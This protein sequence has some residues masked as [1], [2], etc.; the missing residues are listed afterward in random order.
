M[1]YTLENLSAS[2]HI[3]Q[4]EGIIT[5]DRKTATYKLALFRA[6]SEIAVNESRVAVWFQDDEVG[7]PLK[8]I[9]EKWVQYYW[10]LFASDH[11]IPQIRGE[12][13]ESSKPIKFGWNLPNLVEH[14][15]DSGGLT[16][17]VL[18][19]RN[20]SLFPAAEK[21]LQK[22]TRSISQ[23]IIE[24][25]VRH[26]GRALQTGQ[27]FRYDPSKKM[28]LMDSGIWRELSLMAH[29]ILGALKL[30]WAEI[31]SDMSN[32]EVPAGEVLNLLLT[33]PIPE[34]EVGDARKVYSSIVDKECVWSGDPLKRQF[35]VDHVIPFSLWGNNDLWNLLPALS[36]VNRD[37]KDRLPSRSL[38]FRRRD[39]IIY[40][41]RE[42]SKAHKVRF[43]KE[44]K[45]QVEPRARAK[46]DANMNWEEPLFLSM[47][48][49]VQ[50]T[51]TQFGMKPWEP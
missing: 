35:E 33:N 15:S 48:Q 3:D 50:M 42:L 7:I 14:Y 13:L 16:R 31:T 22:V 24:G 1:L 45:S 40:Y 49:S 5:K 9:T 28:V 18:D 27:V 41:W 36:S 4:I 38:I 23:A 20:S 51:T 2:R 37:K 29:W 32:G 46:F 44:A 26:A 17:F 11:F 21:L 10:P 39:W 6:L 47:T 43:D 30:R 25:P 8:S 19:Y 34:R 12:T